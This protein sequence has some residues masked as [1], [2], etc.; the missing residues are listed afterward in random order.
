MP[1]DRCVDGDIEQDGILR[2]TEGIAP[3]QLSPDSP[4]LP[5]PISQT[6]DVSH[7]AGGHVNSCLVA[8]TPCPSRLPVS[9][10]EAS[11]SSPESRESHVA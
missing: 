8:L 5:V 2:R 4:L 6:C 10:A 3:S 1:T 7:V 11:R 9:V